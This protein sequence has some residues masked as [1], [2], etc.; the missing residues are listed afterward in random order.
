MDSCATRPSPDR[1]GLAVAGLDVRP[2]VLDPL[3]ARGDV[4]T[5]EDA[6]EPV[7]RGRVLERDAQQGPLLRVHRRLP[8]LRRVHLAQPLEPL[9]LQLA[10]AV[11][12]LAVRVP[13]AL[14]VEVQLLLALL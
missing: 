2:V 6:E 9:R 4:L 8:Q 1:S 12:V 7:R 14:R 10:L 5:H 3:L 13:L 11:D